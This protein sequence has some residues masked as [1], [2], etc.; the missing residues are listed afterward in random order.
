MEMLR[1]GEAYKAEC[2]ETLK[3]N[4][5]PAYMSNVGSTNSFQSIKDT[6]RY[7]VKL[8]FNMFKLSLH[9]QQDIRC[10][11]VRGTIGRKKRELILD[12]NQITLINNVALFFERLRRYKPFWIEEVLRPNDTGEY[13]T[14]DG[15]LKGTIKLSGGKKNESHDGIKKMLKNKAFDFLQI[16]LARLGGINDA[17]AAYFMARKADGR[18]TV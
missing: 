13:D 7:Y 8:D 15:N 16:N 17:L 12:A 2:E 11:L 10:A 1:N 6:C 4:G 5:F 14:L 3:R 18:F 9:K